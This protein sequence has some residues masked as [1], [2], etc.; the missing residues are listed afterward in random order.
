MIEFAM[1]WTVRG[2]NL[3]GGEISRIRRD[4]PWG[5]HSPLYNG[6]RV[7]IPEVKRP[8]NGVNHPTPYS[9]EVTEDVKWLKQSNYRPG[10]TLRVPGV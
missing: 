9:A 1:G 10:Q 7:S 6:Y 2:S 5:L 3:G 4:P 8:A